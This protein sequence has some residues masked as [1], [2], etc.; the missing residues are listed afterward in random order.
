MS[1]TIL[2]KVLLERAI[3]RLQL[4]KAFMVQQLTDSGGVLKEHGGDVS[5][6]K[7]PCSSIESLSSYSRDSAS[8][9]SLAQRFSIARGSSWKIK[10]VSRSR[11][12]TTQCGLE[13]RGSD[14][15]ENDEVCTIISSGFCLG[16]GFAEGF[17]TQG[18]AKVEFPS[19]LCRFPIGE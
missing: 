9:N 2:L 18:V 4:A 1:T 7:L 15:I 3:W 8:L 19:Y 10:V 12:R 17:S 6:M 13:G 5:T 11:S 14:S 16:K